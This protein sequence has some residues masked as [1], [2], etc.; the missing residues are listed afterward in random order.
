MA[1]TTER[2]SAVPT[3]E[4]PHTR[5]IK[6]DHWTEVDDEEFAAPEPPYVVVARRPTKPGRVP[7]VA[8]TLLGL[9][10]AAGI[11]AGAYLVG[12]S[13]RPSQATVAHRVAGQAAK[14]RV[15]YTGK[16]T[17]AL[18]QQRRHLQKV[19]KQRVDQ[20]SNNGYANGQSQGYTTGQAQGYESGQ[21]VGIDQG[22][23]QG[24]KQGTQAGLAQGDSQGVNDGTCY[25]PQTLADIC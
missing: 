4:K 13:T 23:Q 12:Q 15:F 17:S 5:T 6:L 24:L 1:S 14:D 21:S 19:M 22:K 20:A 8:T 2:G 16:L 10:L 3:A 11:A 7:R 9:L 18:T 25:D